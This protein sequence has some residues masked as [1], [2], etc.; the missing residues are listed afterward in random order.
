MD[1]VPAHWR[2]ARG[3]GEWGAVMVWAVPGGM[4]HRLALHPMC[5]NV[6]ASV[7]KASLKPLLIEKLQRMMVR[8][9][10]VV[11]AG[12]P[13]R[14]ISGAFGSAQEKMFS[15]VLCGTGL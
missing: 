4:L 5:R 8:H 6:F 14:A 7:L 3:S 10:A 12:Q 13:F 9:Q 11:R 15:L 1:K 2:A